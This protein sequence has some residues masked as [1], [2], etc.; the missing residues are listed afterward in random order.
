MVASYLQWEFS[1]NM[2]FDKKLGLQGRESASSNLVSHCELFHFV[3]LLSQKYPRL[4]SLLEGTDAWPRCG[5][6]F[7]EIDI[8]YFQ[9]LHGA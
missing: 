3:P 2:L 6:S 7:D 1:G 8:M 9:T 4:C 5:D